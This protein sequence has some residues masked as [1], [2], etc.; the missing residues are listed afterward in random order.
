MAGARFPLLLVDGH[1]LEAQRG[2]LGV[3]GILIGIVFIG[4]G[5]NTG[6]S[7]MFGFAII[8]LIL[9]AI[10]AVITWFNMRK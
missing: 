9:G 3:L 4:V 1:R 8:F 6:N 10:G 7:D 5:F 2:I